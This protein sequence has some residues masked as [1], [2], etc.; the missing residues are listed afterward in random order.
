M[1]ARRLLGAFERWRARREPL[2]LVTVYDTLGSTYTKAGHRILIAANGDYQGL[3]SGGCLEGDLAERARRVVESGSA[4][5]VTYDMRDE[6]DELWGLG[7]GCNG[8]IRVLLQPLTAEEGYEP[9]ASIAASWLGR[10]PAGVALVVASASGATPAGATLLRAADLER[11]WRVGEAHAGPL[12][13]GCERAAAHGSAELV[14]DELGLEVLYA[15][16]TPIPRVLVLGAGPDAEPLVTLAAEIGWRVTVADHRDAYV[17]P[18]R[19]GTAEAVMRVD[20]RDLGAQLALE[21]YDAIVVMSH[22]LETDR[23][24]LEQAATAPARYIGVLGPPARKARLLDE[25]GSARAQLE[26]RLEGPVGIDIGADSP[27]SI[28]LSITARLQ[29]LFSTRPGRS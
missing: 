12:A 20:P 28:A 29:Q 5:A 10:H 21:R 17:E 6:A 14:T 25:L 2:A 18:G 16:L 4:A 9:F 26:D 23:R 13:A 7:I 3:V 15:P 22:H 24:Y 8:L 11:R 19:F 1:S 27:E